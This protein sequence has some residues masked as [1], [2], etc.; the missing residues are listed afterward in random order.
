MNTPRYRFLQHLLPFFLLLAGL[1]SCS[2]TEN[3]VEP[4][5]EER[6]A[7][8]KQSLL[9]NFTAANLQQLL[10]S[11]NITMPFALS[12]SVTSLSI[13]YYTVDAKGNLLLASGAL[14]VPQGPGQFPLASIQHGTQTR[15]TLVASVSPFNST[16]G[17]IG[18][19]MASMGYVVVVPD[20]PGFG[21]SK[22]IH[23]Y[24][25]AESLTPCVIDLMRAARA[26]STTNQVSLNGKVFLTGYSEGGYVTLAT[27]QA[28]EEKYAS[29]F[30]LTGV[31]PMAG[32]Y[33][34][35]GTIESILQTNTYTTPA[36][37]A[38]FLTAYNDVYKWNRLESFFNPPYASRMPGL[39]DGSKTWGE[40][41]NQLPTTFSA[42]M[43]PAFVA[44]YLGGSEQAVRAAVQENTLLN[45]RPRAPIH[46]FHG[47]ADDVVPI[48][49]AH[50]AMSVFR[51]SGASNVQLTIIPGGTHESAGPIAVVGALQW[52]RTM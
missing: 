22:G 9:G 28:I 27:Q 5:R 34:L 50:T 49:N 18:L 21:V 2:K 36:Y 30:I 10:S 26:F 38:F 14:V 41:V 8:V 43:N 31:A 52:F 19:V 40:I 44:N 24:L 6:G 16:E 1:Q 45:W 47:D 23:P 48:Q 11:N 17:L 3:P 29:E 12:Y 15:S 7:I 25:H 42:L 32:P 37:V 51:S 46:F 20:Y 13:E 35:Q 4:I 39:F 33:D